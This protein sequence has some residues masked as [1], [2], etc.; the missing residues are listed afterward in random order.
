MQPNAPLIW[1]NFII[2]KSGC[3]MN[4]PTNNVQMIPSKL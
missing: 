1:Q 3:Y 2:A 4:T